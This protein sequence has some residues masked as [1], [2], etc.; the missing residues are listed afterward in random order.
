MEC[1]HY[2]AKLVSFAPVC[3]YCGIT[4][5]SFVEDAETQQLRQ[6]YAV[7]RP[8]CFLCKSEGKTPFVK[9]PTNVKKHRRLSRYFCTA[10]N[11]ILS[12]SSLS[13]HAIVATLNLLQNEDLVQG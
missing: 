12:L 5:D 7:V 4:E 8:L 2:S 9:M 6:E 3:Y 13:F 11:N 1:Q 10:L